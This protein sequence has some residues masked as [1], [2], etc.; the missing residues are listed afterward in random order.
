MTHFKWIIVLTAT[1]V[2][3]LA[4]SC[5]QPQEKGQADGHEAEVV[6]ASTGNF[7]APITKDGAVD[8]SQVAALV[9]GDEPV[10]VTASGTIAEVCQHSG[11]WL[12]FDLGNGQTM[13]VNMKDHA[14][15]IPKDAAGKK[16]G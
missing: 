14:Y 15:A 12:T 16:C 2:L 10:A 8:A 1:V 3:V 9:T 5:N 13:Q 4:S 11:C 7:G 6:L